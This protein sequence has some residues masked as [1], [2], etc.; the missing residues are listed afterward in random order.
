MSVF[1]I[2]ELVEEIFD[3]LSSWELFK[4]YG[5]NKTS[6]ICAMS[7]LKKRHTIRHYLSKYFDDNDNFMKFAKEARIYLFGST[8][9]QCMMHEWFKYTDLDIYCTSEHQAKCLIEYVLKHEKYKKSKQFESED[10]DYILHVKKLYK[11]HRPGRGRID[12]VIGDVDIR[13]MIKESGYATHVMNYWDFESDCGYS[14]SSVDAVHKKSTITYDT[15]VRK[16]GYND[17][18]EDI[19][20]Q[21]ADYKIVPYC[22][23]AINAYV[24]RD[25]KFIVPKKED[26][27]IDELQFS[28]ITWISSA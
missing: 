1:D 27:N 20:K 15:I 23:E 18:N 5:I 22:L 10:Y 4:I 14:I 13:T 9:L 19:L 3:Y 17:S 2:A 11:V 21:I 6:N 25:F 12:I 16:V 28:E 8:V 7:L 24:D 26:H